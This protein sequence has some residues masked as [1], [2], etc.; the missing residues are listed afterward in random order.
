MPKRMEGHTTNA[1]CFEAREKVAFAEVIAV[2]WP[3]SP[4]RKHK[5]GN[6]GAS[7]FVEVAPLYSCKLLL[8]PQVQERSAKSCAEIGLRPFLFF[9][10][11]N[12]CRV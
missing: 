9:V 8:I 10:V 5:L 11:V 2:K 6:P 4:R 12:S 1:R 3:A 7:A